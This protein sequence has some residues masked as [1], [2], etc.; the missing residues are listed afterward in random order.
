MATAS[1][2]APVRDTPL[3]ETTGDKTDNG[4]VAPAR[5]PAWLRALWHYDPG[6]DYDLEARLRL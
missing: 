4:V 1:S 6:Y 2:V 3:Q 5:H